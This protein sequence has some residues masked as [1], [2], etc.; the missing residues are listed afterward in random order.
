[1]KSGIV[2]KWCLGVGLIPWA[3]A[4]NCLAANPNVAES[5]ASGAEPVPTLSHDAASKSPVL[6]EAASPTNDIAEAEVKAVSA[7]KPVPPNIRPSSPVSELIKLANSGV[8]EGV[9]M[10]YVTNSTGTFNL[11]AEEIIY[12]KDVGVPD[13]VVTA[14]ILRDQA[15][16][17]QPSLAQ[18][19]PTPWVSPLPE[20]QPV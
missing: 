2:C 11:G 1:M 15:L 19:A 20:T 16:R 18:A 3:L 7:E 13:P 12:L 4:Y 9:M 10:A 14:M 6:I 8:E 5:K 17:T